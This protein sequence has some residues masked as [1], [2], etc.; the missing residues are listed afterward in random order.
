MATVNRFTFSCIANHFTLPL[1][2]LLTLTIELVYVTSTKHE[3]MQFPR[4]PQKI[5]GV[6]ILLHS[7]LER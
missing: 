2:K 1:R 5:F 4:H 3:N 6:L 7:T